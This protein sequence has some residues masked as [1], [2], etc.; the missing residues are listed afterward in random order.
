MAFN[1]CSHFSRIKRLRSLLYTVISERDPDRALVG[2]FRSPPGQAGVAEEPG[3]LPLQR[4]AEPGRCRCC[5]LSPGVSPSGPGVVVMQLNVPNG[6]QAPQ[7][8][9]VVQ[10]SHCK[11]YS[12][13]QRG[14][15]PGDLY[16][17]DTSAQVWRGL[18]RRERTPASGMPGWAGK[19]G[20]GHSMALRPTWDRSQALGLSNALPPP[21]QHPA[22]QPHHVPHPVPDTVSCHQ[23]QQCLHRA[24]PPP[25]PHTVPPAHGPGTR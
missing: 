1:F 11:Y 10:W 25:R 2:P 18:G 14:Q 4:C 6:T 5:P 12:L 16:N 20:R 23:P 13:E 22:E 21:G 7:N 9:P 17:P 3:Q 24:E 15:K 8:P 19:W